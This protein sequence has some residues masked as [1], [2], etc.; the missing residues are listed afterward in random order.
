MNV[1]LS[2]TELARLEKDLLSQPV[3]ES[4]N[5]LLTLIVEVRELRRKQP[6]SVELS[7]IATFRQAVFEAM[8]AEQ[9]PDA[10]PETEPPVDYSASGYRLRPLI[11]KS[12]RR[13]NP[14]PVDYSYGPR[15]LLP[16]PKP[17]VE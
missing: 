3:G 2:D 10:K 11:A 8:K 6:T 15:P 12:K 16:E 9:P 5:L 17:R 7:V 13:T 4:R 1:H 14:E